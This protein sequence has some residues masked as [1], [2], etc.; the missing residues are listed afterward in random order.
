[1]EPVGRGEA[2]SIELH[3]ILKT[4]FQKVICIVFFFFFL[5]SKP[6]SHPG[7]YPLIQTSS[8]HP[9][10]TGTHMPR[11]TLQKYS[12]AL[13]KVYGGVSPSPLEDAIV[14]QERSRI[15]FTRKVL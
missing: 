4:I 5:P 7:N 8:Q 14:Q 1:M 11:P 12:V 9:C 3:F 6:Y 13:R 10:E 2:V 15:S